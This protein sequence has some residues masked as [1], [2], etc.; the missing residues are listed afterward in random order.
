[1]LLPLPPTPS[2]SWWVV[3]YEFLLLAGLAFCI[4][5]NSAH[6]T[7][8]SWVGLFAVASVMYIYGTSEF[9]IPTDPRAAGWPACCQVFFWGGIWEAG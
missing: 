7:M 4:M 2:F 5:T 9:A 6:R 1:M 3:A 8:N